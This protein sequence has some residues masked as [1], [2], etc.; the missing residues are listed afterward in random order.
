MT[1]DGQTATAA[2]TPRL[3]AQLQRVQSLMEGGSWRTLAQIATYTGDPESSISARLRD[4]RKT[5]FGA[6][7]VQRRHRTQGQW[8]Y[9]CL[10]PDRD[11]QIG[12]PLET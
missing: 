9:R 3:N 8:E 5:K 2:D 6:W 7:D 10:K 11:P 4:L 12:L 1:F